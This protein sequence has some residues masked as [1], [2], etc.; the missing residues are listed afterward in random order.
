MPFYCSISDKAVSSGTWFGL[1]SSKSIFNGEVFVSDFDIDSIP[2]PLKSSWEY[3]KKNSSKLVECFSPVYDLFAGYVLTSF[4]GGEEIGENS[5]SHSPQE[6]L[7]NV[8]RE[9]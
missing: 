9:F 1:S 7:K 2:E 3:F 6:F 4:T 8:V 5:V